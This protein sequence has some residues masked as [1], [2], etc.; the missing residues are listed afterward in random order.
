MKQWH[1]DSLLT[2]KNA[3]NEL[4]ASVFVFPIRKRIID[5]S[6]LKCLRHMF[7]GWTGVDM[8]VLKNVLNVVPFYCHLV[9]F[10]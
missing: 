10:L 5:P 9:S 3:I 7:L 8:H 6:G 1:K 2:G 4:S